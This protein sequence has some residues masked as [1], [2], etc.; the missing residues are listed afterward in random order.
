MKLCCAQIDCLL[1][2]KEQ[3]LAKIEQY[4]K[5][6][7]Q[8][9]P[10]LDLLVFPELATTG[11]EG[12]RES[13]FLWAETADGPSAQKIAAIAKRYQVNIVY[14]FAEK[15]TVLKGVLYNSALFLNREGK[16]LGCYRKVHP[17][18][19]ENDWCRAGC[20]YP[21]IETDFGK[22]GIF[23]CWDTA[24]PEVARS[25]ALQGAD[26]LIVPTNWEAPYSRD[27]DLVTTARA[28]DNV[29][30]LIG[31]NRVG[32]DKTISFFGH[33]KILNATG[34][35]LAACNN[36]I[37]SLVY[38]EVDLQESARL[39]HQYYTLL[40]DRRPDTYGLITKPY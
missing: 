40:Q 16:Q 38:A 11:Y 33:S 13:F 39:R 2:Q 34:Q 19:I 23:I 17:F 21:I 8:T 35:E 10:G 22:V 25:Y 37:E 27:W 6:A 4:A 31:C 7:T 5:E 3:N 12:N 26:L 18:G 14:G 15:D 24:F 30:P 29:L 36:H 1:G 28:F 32:Q 20:T 9:Y